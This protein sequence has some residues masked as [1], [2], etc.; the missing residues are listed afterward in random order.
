MADE[1][2]ST[3]HPVQIETVVMYMPPWLRHLEDGIGERID[4]GVGSFSRHER[5]RLCTLYPSQAS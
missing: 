2:N 1:R 4:G 5:V 3:A